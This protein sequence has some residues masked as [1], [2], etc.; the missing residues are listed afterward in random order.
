MRKLRDISGLTIGIDGRALRKQCTGVERMVF[1]FI[2][3]LSAMGAQRFVLFVDDELPADLRRRWPHEVVTEP[4]RFRRGQQLF[5][6]WLALQLRPHL[7]RLNVDAFYSPHTKF[8]LAPVRRIVTVHGLEWAFHAEGYKLGERLKQWFWF[9]ASIWCADG[10]VTFAQNT[11]RDIR[12]LKPRRHIPVCVVPEGVSPEFRQLIPDRT[13]PPR[14]GINGPFILSVCSLEPRKNIDNLIRAYARARASNPA[15]PLLVLVGRDAWKSDRLRALAA[16]EGV[17]DR[18]VFAGYV[19]DADLVELYNQAELF[20]FPSWYEGFGL[21]V[22]EAMACGTPV[23]TSTTS[24]LPEVA[25]T[26]AILV[27]PGSVADLA[28]ALQRVCGD[29]V[30]REELRRRGPAHA[31]RFSWR[32]MTREICEFIVARS[33]CA[34]P[35]GSR[36]L[37]PLAESTEAGGRP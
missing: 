36:A 27:N 2:E 4:V 33:A 16:R 12:R 13:V 8:P 22:L 18:V 25:G 6:F 28:A 24:S 7:R 21:P 5:D 17:A 9:T 26:A 37:Q 32:A 30:L 19:A 29:A 34:A 15:L 20:V 31:A 35:P 23:I 1:H 10:I 3:N 11:L 14:L